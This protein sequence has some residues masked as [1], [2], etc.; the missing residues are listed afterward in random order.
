MNRR[1]ARHLKVREEKLYQ[2]TLDHTEAKLA[3]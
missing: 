1:I 2:L 3:D